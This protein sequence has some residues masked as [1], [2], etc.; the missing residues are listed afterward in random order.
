MYE[1]MN[2]FRGCGVEESPK[3][4]GWINK[5]W[6]GGWSGKV[7]LAMGIPLTNS[8]SKEWAECFW[9]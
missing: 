2:R 1:W 6:V 4:T 9:L 8:E 7:I 3:A 5:V